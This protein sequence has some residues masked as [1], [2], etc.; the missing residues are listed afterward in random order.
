[1]SDMDNMGVGGVLNITPNML[2]MF[3]EMD[4][5]LERIA[6]SSESMSKSLERGFIG[7]A[8]AGKLTDDMIQRLADKI[9]YLNM[10]SNGLDK[11]GHS[12]SDASIQAVGF[13]ASISGAADNINKISNMGL[14]DL[15]IAELTD[16]IKKIKY[17]LTNLEDGGK[18]LSIGEQQSLVNSMREMES[19]LKTQ[20]KSERQLTEEAVKESEKRIKQIQREAKERAKAYQAK[21]YSSNTS[22]QG[23]L[24][25]SNTANTFARQA[26]ALDYLKKARMSLSTADADYKIKLD[27]INSAMAKHNQA[28]M[29]AGMKSQQLQSRHRNLMDTAGQLARQLALL[30][31]VSQIEG[32][33]NQI[34]KVRGEFELNQRALEAILQNKLKA[35]TL[36]QQTVD[37]AVKSPFQIKDLISYTKQLAAYRIES[38]KLFETTKRLADVSAG[39]GVDMQRLILAY[40]QV[41]AA[42]YLRGTEVRQ[43]TEA[44]VNMYGELQ[45]YFKEVKGEAYTTA[46]IVDMISKR[47]VTF[48][49]VEA[50]FQ[51]MT[52]KGGIFYRM[53]EIQSETLQGKISNLKD[54]FD[55]MFNE[56]GKENE[57][58][59]KGTIDSVSSILKHW[60]DVVSAGK[61]FAAVLILLYTQSLLTGNS[62]RKVFS[63]DFAA[64]GMKQANSIALIGTGLKN[65]GKAAVIFGRN[66]KMAFM[67]NLPL[68]GITA[69]ISAISGLVTWAKEY[70]DGL[71][72]IAKENGKLISDLH[73]ISRAYESISKSSGISDDDS[74][75]EEKK[76]KLYEL[77]GL[78]EKSGLKVP[79]EIDDISQKDVD[80]SYKVLLDGYEAYLKAKKALD[81]AFH[82][83]NSRLEWGGLFGNNIE[84]DSKDL[85]ASYENLLSKTK[86]LDDAI[87]LLNNNYKVLSEEQRNLLADSQQREEGENEA[88]YLYRQADAILKV[89]N[90]LPRLNS[91]MRK[92]QM[93]GLDFVRSYSIRLDSFKK[94]EKEF[95]DEWMN[96]LGKL[97]SQY[98][99]KEWDLHGKAVIEAVINTKAAENGWEDW[100]IKIAKDAAQADFKIS[101]SAD[102]KSIEDTTNYLDKRINDFLSGREYKIDF[103]V[104]SL[105]NDPLRG[106]HDEIDKLNKDAKDAMDSL[107]RLERSKHELYT[108]ED[109]A[110]SN[111]GKLPTD[112]EWAKYVSMFM[113]AAVDPARVEAI[114]K[115]DIISYYKSAQKALDDINTEYGT[116]KGEKKKGNGN[117]GNDI[118]SERISLVKKLNAEYEKLRERMSDIDAD[119]TV[120]SRYAS[121]IKSLGLDVSNLK[122]DKQSIGKWLTEYSKAVADLKK[123]NNAE[124]TGIELLDAFDMD[125]IDKEIETVRKKVESMFESLSLHDKLVGLGLG[126]SDIQTMF[127]GLTM[128]FTQIREGFEEAF[129]GKEGGKWEK[130]REDALQKLMQ[131]EVD[132]NRANLEQLTKDYKTRLSEQ[133]QLDKWYYG[134]RKK[135][136]EN[137]ELKK[138]PELKKQYEENLKREYDEKTSQNA[139]KQFQNSGFYI[140]MFENMEYTSTR[141]LH[142]MRE[143]LD[144][145][146]SSLSG[147]PPEQLKQVVSAMDEIDAQITS[148][149]PFEG[150]TNSLKGFVQF[151]LERNRLEKD[152]IESLSH[153]DSLQGDAAMQSKKVEALKAQWDL[154]VKVNG[155][156]SKS[157][158]QAKEEYETEK[159]KL[160][161]ILEQLKAQGLI[162]KEL[163]EQ[164]KDGAKSEKT[165]KESAKN[166]AGQGAELATSVNGFYDML[167]NDFGLNLSEDFSRV[168]DGVGNF[169]GSIADFDIS[170]PVGSAINVL[171]G[172]GKTIAAVFG[173]KNHDEELQK[174]IEEHQKAIERLQRAYDGLKEAMDNAWDMSSLSESKDKS[175][176]N[177]KE[178]NEQLQSMIAAERDKKDSNADQIQEWQDQ[179]EDN[180]KAIKELEESMTEELGGF[181]SENNYKSAAQAF[182][183]AWVDAFNE[184]ED[185]LESLEDTFDDYITNLIKKQSMMRVVKASL[186]GLFEEID[187]AV[188]EGSEG[189]FKLTKEELE[190]ISNIADA[191]LSNL[192]ENLKE[193]MES[194][195]YLGSK[196]SSSL[197]AL[198]QGIENITESTA[199]ALEALLNSIRFF[200]SRQTSDI[201]SIRSILENRY[202]SNEDSPILSELRS[203]T[204][205]IKSINSLLDSVIRPGHSKGGYGI[206]CIL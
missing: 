200:V 63:V 184:G 71:I 87:S 84:Q 52:D 78:Y 148:R 94:Q 173:V 28:L 16:K 111:G 147:L 92:A 99:E 25:F 79:I 196:K 73:N 85:S 133:L 156:G 188:S 127:P 60:E 70:K 105:A 151:A 123:R 122:F 22:Y 174:E 34:A 90:S 108:K 58:V 141:M 191:A 134:E 192:D 101:F 11:I 158:N 40:G 169:F 100:K 139:W 193:L 64:S 10:K 86:D 61:A 47:M 162:S 48:G 185:A 205:L 157:A 83:N 187:R 125:K 110:K 30:F 17:E 183:D 89:T 180:N 4:K 9:Q 20:M 21:N 103:T 149:N 24:D 138:T 145:L 37:L 150:L 120:R 32:Y 112:E 96:V 35:D 12:L 93:A 75:F 77:Q 81:V 135:I 171:T 197:S 76:K 91:E 41:K 49:D 204:S 14:G 206:K 159:A 68:I 18:R 36:F 62:L 166:I 19:Q 116:K 104:K 137:E 195:G 44:G 198:Q 182:A 117:K 143:K 53:Q 161:V 144:E 97:R 132:Y 31:S 15:N 131:K 170:K 181:G 5:K 153:E 163:A 38:D 164:I 115:K 152:Y 67:T 45:S 126:E 66:L 56:I 23:A 128:T 175:V 43:F 69:A 6:V 106:L 121:Q 124:R 154:E 177:L 13:S 113:G 46:Q 160:N 199:E 2:K 59:L 186:G 142:A 202:G 50:V 55:I 179:I 129:S 80:K 51:R 119:K 33:I 72:E 98:T 114:A 54:S 65:A 109:F 8:N 172:L 57:N 3:D 1:M 140:D 190:N 165:F 203:Q 146:R 7:A 74:I 102:E 130:A 88:E 155:M 95:L 26:K 201:T 189:G 168:V 178:Q 167:Q 29:E 42:A 176:E 194:L 82:E 27:A 107:D 136:E 118:I 39:L